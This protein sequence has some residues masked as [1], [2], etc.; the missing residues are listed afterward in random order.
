MSR[1]REGRRGPDRRLGYL[2]VLLLVAGVTVVILYLT[3]ILDAPR[4]IG[5]MVALLGLASILAQRL[6]RPARGRRRPRRT[7]PDNRPP[8]RGGTD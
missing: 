4:L 6:R 2:G 1:L 7:T 8:H 3:G 5:A